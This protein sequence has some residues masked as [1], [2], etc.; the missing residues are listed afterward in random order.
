MIDI[1]QVLDGTPPNTGVAVTTTRASTNTID[2]LAARDVGVPNPLGIHVV[3]TEAFV[4]GTSVVVEQQV[5]ATEGGTFLTL[6]RSAV[7]LT[8][9]LTAGQEIYRVP[10]VMNQANNQSAGVLNAPGR[11]FRLLY[12]VVGTFTAG[13]V[14][15]YVNP[16]MDRNAFYAYPANYTVYVDPDEI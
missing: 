1:S 14:F 11:Y 15:A 8:A 2:L 13:A 10:I 3:V 5:C 9:N 6:N 4:G 16:N 12:T 7:I